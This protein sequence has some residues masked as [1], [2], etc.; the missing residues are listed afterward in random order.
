[1]HRN[2]R[3]RAKEGNCLHPSRRDAAPVAA[4]LSYRWHNPTLRNRLQ[5]CMYKLK[6]LPLFVNCILYWSST[7]KAS[8]Y[9]RCSV[10][11]CDNP[12]WANSAFWALFGE[13]FSYRSLQERIHGRSWQRRAAG[14]ANPG[15]RGVTIEMQ[16]GQMRLGKMRL[17]KMR[18]GKIPNLLGQMTHGK[19]PNLLGQM[20][21]GKIPNLLG[22][23][24]LGAV[25]DLVRNPGR[26]QRL[27]SQVGLGE[28]IQAGNTKIH[29]RSMMR[30]MWHVMKRKTWRSRL[31][32][33]IGIPSNQWRPKSKQPS[34]VKRPQRRFQS[35]LQPVRLRIWRSLQWFQRCCRPGPGPDWSSL[36]PRVARVAHLHLRYLL[37]LRQREGWPR[38]RRSWKSKRWALFQSLA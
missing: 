7:F 33:R 19:I 12:C 32:G 29:S 4:L 35:L 8:N 37:P 11:L 21:H 9:L 24:M 26:T 2:D 23:M 38:R 6:A 10:G 18:L 25:L 22:Q 31:C 5:R 13:S 34:K 14:A 36:L 3:S 27:Q 30:G 1:M 16:L 17:G 15:L 20:T 28:M